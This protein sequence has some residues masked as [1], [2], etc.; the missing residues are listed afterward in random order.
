MLQN[1]KETD[2]LKLSNLL[3][4]KETNQPQTTC[5]KFATVGQGQ[6]YGVNAVLHK[7]ATLYELR[8][9]TP[10]AQ[11]YVIPASHFNAFIEREDLRAELLPFLK[12]IEVQFANKLVRSIQKHL[13]CFEANKRNFRGT[14]SHRV[15]PTP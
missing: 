12:E 4:Q 7:R 9:M 13:E 1:I 11:Y 14:L 10:N 15:S 8:S 5:I 3:K 6:L 2:A